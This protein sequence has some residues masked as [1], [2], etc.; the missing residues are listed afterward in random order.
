VTV[1]DENIDPIA[2]QEKLLLE[3]PDIQYRVISDFRT[4]QQKA[5]SFE[6]TS[7]SEKLSSALEKE[8]SYRLTR[9]NS[10]VEFSG[11]SLSEGFYKQLISAIIA[12]FLLMSW[13]VFVIF[14]SSWKLRYFS[15]MLTFFGVSLSMKNVE[16][17]TALSV[18]LILVSA[19]ALFIVKNVK[20][21]EKITG[22]V[23]GIVAILCLLYYPS[24]IFLVI[25][26]LALAV[27][28]VSTSIPSFA[29][30]LSA[31]ADILMTLVAVNMIGI[32]ISGAGIIAFLMLIGYS[33][34]T[35][36]LLTTR[37]F[38][39]KEGHINKRLFEAFKTGITMTLTAIA[40]VGI[41]LILVYSFSETLTQVFGIVLIG[42]GFD[43]LNTWLT[44]ASL[45]KWF[46]EVKNIA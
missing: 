33:V 36:I 23:I 22:A 29:I 35:D 43:I 44:I 2:M 8:I 13:V 5:V 39:D 1:F 3:F 32:N 9:E 7:E 42:L 18:A 17:V 10:S 37:M 27:L 14:S 24:Q 15:T 12:A 4:G 40:S 19:L 38:R 41:S 30:I 46:M 34:D 20:K 21:A 45:L 6:T 31:F 26:G 11:A 28:Y 25:A 16:W